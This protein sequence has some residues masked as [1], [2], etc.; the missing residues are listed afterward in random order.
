MIFT[1]LIWVLIMSSKYKRESHVS[2]RRDSKFL[3]LHVAFLLYIS[4]S[5]GSFNKQMVTGRTLF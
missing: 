1:V 2:I 4:T 5:S 3:Y